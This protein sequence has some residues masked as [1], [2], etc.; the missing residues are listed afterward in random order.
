VLNYVKGKTGFAGKKMGRINRIG[1]ESR[2]AR[3]MP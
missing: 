3:S 2:T 1:S